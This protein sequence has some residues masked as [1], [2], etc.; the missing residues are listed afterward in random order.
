MCKEFNF[1]FIEN[2]NIVLR[3]HGHHDGVHLNVEGSDMLRGNLLDV[4]NC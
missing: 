3:D 1:T 4:L 2:K